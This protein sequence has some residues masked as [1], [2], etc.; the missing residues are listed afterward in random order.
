MAEREIILTYVLRIL[1]QLAFKG[2]TCLKKTYF[3]KTGR[4]SMDLDFTSVSIKPEELRSKLKRSLHNKTVY[5]VDFKI[6]EQIMKE[7]DKCI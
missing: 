7:L 2:G 1:P 3:G 6:I 5:G 4:F